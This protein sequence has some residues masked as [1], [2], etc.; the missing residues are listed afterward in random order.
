MYNLISGPQG[1]IGPKGL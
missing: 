1:P